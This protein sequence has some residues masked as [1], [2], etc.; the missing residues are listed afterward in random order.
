MVHASE[1]GHWYDKDGR[2]A[3]TLIGANGKERAPTVR[4]ARKLNLYPSVTTIIRCAAA[5]GLEF[6]KAKQAILAALTLPRNEGEFEDAYLD[7]ILRDSKEQARKAAERGT[8]IHAAIQGHYEGKQPD[9]ALWPFVQGAMKAVGP[10]VWDAEKSFAHPLGFGGKVDLSSDEWVIDFKTKEFSPEDPIKGWPEQAM[11]LAAYRVGLGFTRAR[12][13][14]VFVSVTHPG[15]AVMYEWPEEELS[16]G[17]EKF[18]ALLG[19]WQADRKYI[20]TVEKI[21][22]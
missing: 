4:D 10:G 1:S 11:Q 6:W 16:Q 9:E 20:P 12:C 18:R 19:Y 2:P 14:N 5:P 3:Y 13:G 15:H 17:W 22:A 7:R 21:A 8:E